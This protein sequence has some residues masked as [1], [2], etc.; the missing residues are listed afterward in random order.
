MTL[1]TCE[2][3]D[4][5]GKNAKQYDNAIKY[6]GMIQDFVRNGGHYLG[7]CLGAYLADSAGF[8]L[9]PKG[10][11]SGSEIERDGAPIH[12]DDDTV[13]KVDYRFSD[14]S[15]K[16][17]RWV[18]FQEGAVITGLNEDS[19]QVIAQYTA[20]DDVAASVTPYGKGFVG[21]IGFHPEADET[22]CKFP[23]A[24]SN[25]LGVCA[26]CFSRR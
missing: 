9:L 2:E 13:V 6:K 8:D 25:V 15:V 12:T 21:L 18:Y 26:D 5:C 20:N 4:D 24:N 17:G 7:V 23:I 11:H 22:W 14:G 19:D 16:N 1:H 3:F 10:V